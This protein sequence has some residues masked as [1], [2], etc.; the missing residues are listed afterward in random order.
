MSLEERSIWERLDRWG[1]GP[2]KS[3]VGAALIALDVVFFNTWFA[4]ALGVLL[5]ACDVWERSPR[6][7]RAALERAGSGGLTGKAPKVSP[8][9]MPPFCFAWLAAIT[10][11]TGVQP[12]GRRN[13]LKPGPTCCQS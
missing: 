7:K 5:I 2:W 4:V 8:S 9:V 3:A 11:I 1:N 12:D 6:G 13:S 10:S